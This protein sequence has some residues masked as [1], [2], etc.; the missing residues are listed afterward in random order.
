MQLSPFSEKGP[1][2][3]VAAGYAAE[4][5]WVMAP[6]SERALELAALH[7]TSVIADVAAG[8]GTLTLRAAPHV[9]QVHALDF[10]ER[11]L[12]ELAENAKKLALKNVELHHGDG[13]A[14]PFADASFDAAFSMFGLMFFPNRV[15][16]HAELH[17][18]LKPGGVAVVSS[19][20]DVTQSSVMMLMFGALCAADPSRPQPKYDPN[21]LENPELLASEMEAGGFADVV[22]HTCVNEFDAPEPAAFWD[23]M[24]RSSAPLV[25]LRKKLGEAAWATQAEKAKAFLAERLAGAPSKLG[26][27]ALLAVGHKR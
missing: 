20:A 2:D 22:V 4:A 13:Q 6:F 15:K 1:W 27:K 16:G 21:S 3:D 18:V 8:P 12:D 11:M 14:L 26:A 10:S 5:H 25:M 23:S 24:V 17:R 9:A 19:W 7:E